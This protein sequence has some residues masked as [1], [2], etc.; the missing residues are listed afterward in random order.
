MEGLGYTNHF[1]VAR[2]REED[3]RAGTI[4]VR[5]TLPREL[6]LTWVQKITLPLNT[7]LDWPAAGSAEGFVVLVMQ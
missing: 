2:K 4:T 7:S 5:P 6:V 1:E 3:P